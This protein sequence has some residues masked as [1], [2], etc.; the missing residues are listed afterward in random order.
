[1]LV[2]RRRQSKGRSWTRRW[3][4]DARNLADGA[5]TQDLVDSDKVGR[6]RP[7]IGRP[8][9][10][11]RSAGRPRSGRP[12]AAAEEAAG[13]RCRRRGRSGWRPGCCRSR[14]RSTPTSDA[15]GT[16]REASSAEPS[17][18][19]TSLAGADAEESTPRP[20]TSSH[21]SVTSVMTHWQR[22]PVS[23]THSTVHV[24]S[25]GSHTK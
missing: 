13:R 5:S 17:P 16:V 11:G 9:A 21:R 3:W 1:M 15:T 24:N 25:L 22:R 6:T 19:L 20:M 7:V 2:N 14:S 18:E 10:V 4:A 8:K 23:A 12:A